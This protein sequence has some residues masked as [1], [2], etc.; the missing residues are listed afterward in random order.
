MVLINDDIRRMQLVYQIL[1]KNNITAKN[2]SK[3]YIEFSEVFYS[4]GKL[5]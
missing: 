3:L 4:L 1:H 5:V 2:F